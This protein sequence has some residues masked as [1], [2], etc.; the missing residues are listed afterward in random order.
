MNFPTSSA[1]MKELTGKF[2][3]ATTD[4]EIAMDGD[5]IGDV[6]QW[7][8]WISDS[9]ESPIPLTTRGAPKGETQK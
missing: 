1:R 9:F 5:T 7:L 4:G 6:Y 3:S 8:L 2:E